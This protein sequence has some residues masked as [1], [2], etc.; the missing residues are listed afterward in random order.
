MTIVVREP[1][2]VFR[3]RLTFLWSKRIGTWVTVPGS[4]VMKSVTPEGW[5]G[6]GLSE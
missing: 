4:Y 1:S 2:E 5:E 3:R 6:M